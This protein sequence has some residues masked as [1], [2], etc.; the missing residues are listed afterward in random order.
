MV[1]PALAARVDLSTKSGRVS[2]VDVPL[3]RSV[4]DRRHVSGRLGDGGPRLTARTGN[5]D[6]R[7]EAY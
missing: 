3:D 7:L 1:D 2:V 6:V 5:G 4:D